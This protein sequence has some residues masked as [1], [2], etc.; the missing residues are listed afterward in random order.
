MK[1]KMEDGT[2][3]V[4]AMDSTQY[5]IIKSWNLMRYNRL[6]KWVEGSVTLELLD[7]FSSIVKLPDSIEAERQRLKDIQDAVD[8]ERLREEPHPLYKYPVKIPL[9][10]HQV[11][12]AN[13]AL[14]TFGLIKPEDVPKLP[15]KPPEV[16]ETVQESLDRW[17]DYLEG[18]EHAFDDAPAGGKT[19]EE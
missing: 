16:H 11:R 15:A 12:A 13:M 4:A 1:M 3:I 6:M 18:N 2:L 7:K 9:F 10:E 8:R 17:W 5:A 19:D 14:I